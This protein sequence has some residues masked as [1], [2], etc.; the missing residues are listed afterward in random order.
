MKKNKNWHVAMFGHPPLPCGNVCTSNPDMR[1]CLDI[2]PWHVAMF[3][4]PTLT[5]GNVWTSNPDM[6]QCLDINYIYYCK[7]SDVICLSNKNYC[8]PS[9][10]Y[11]NYVCI[12]TWCFVFWQVSA[13]INDNFLVSKVLLQRIF[14]S[15]EE[16]SECDFWINNAVYFT[17]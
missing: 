10:P 3:G 9:K 14:C 7:F 17:L 12:V 2:H 5:C 8:L 13:K 11:N 4:H 16:N 1:Q 6:W 15:R